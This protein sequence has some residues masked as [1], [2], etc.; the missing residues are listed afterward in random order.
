MKRALLVFVLACG[1]EPEVA[2]SPPSSVDNP[3]AE[4]DLTL[5]RLTPDAVQRLHIETR[6]VEL[7]EIPEQRRMGGEVI[8]PPGRTATVSAPVA[9]V[10]RL[11]GEWGP[12]SAVQAGDVLLRLTPLAPSDRDTRARTDREVAVARAASA[13]A[14]ARLARTRALA[15]EN[16]GSQRAVEE[17]TVA[18]DTALA[19]VEAAEARGRAMGSSP[20][21]SDVTMTVRATV[22]GVVRSASV[23]SGQAVAAGAPLLEIVAVDALWVR[24]PVYSGDLHRIA[25]DAPASVESLDQG[26]PTIARAIGGPPTA[27]PLLG[28]VDRY[29]ALEGASF[30]PGERV[31]VSVPL[32]TR[33]SERAVPA[34][35]VIVDAEG[36]AWLYVCEDEGVYRRARVEVLRHHEALAVLSRGPEAGTCVVSVGAAEV[37]GSEFEPGH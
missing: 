35:A 37:Y 1:G 23:R 17:A 7:H 14:E 28:T 15:A 30:V 18:R 16:A 27:D 24:V 9:G 26:A 22:T 20:L 19:D 10:V 21:L 8:V 25:D 2:H 34:S 11:S 6:A 36:G 32:A 29:Y 12:G 4:S 31:L 13:A 5:V 33:G 3:V